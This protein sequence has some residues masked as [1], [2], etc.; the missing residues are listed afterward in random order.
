MVE[1]GSARDTSLFIKINIRI[2]TL[3]IYNFN[4]FQLY[5]VILSIIKLKKTTFNW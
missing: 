3:E 5:L 4:F 2:T 1:K